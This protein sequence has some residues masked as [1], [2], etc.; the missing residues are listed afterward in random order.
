MSRLNSLRSTARANEQFS[1]GSVG[2]PSRIEART[3]RMASE[4]KISRILLVARSPT[5]PVLPLTQHGHTFPSAVTTG[6]DHGCLH[7]DVIMRLWKAAGGPAGTIP[8]RISS[9]PSPIRECR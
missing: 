9:S 7:A 8:A 3:A 4:S 5:E 1:H 2:L 6:D